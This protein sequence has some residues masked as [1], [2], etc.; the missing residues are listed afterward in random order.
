MATISNR[1]TGRDF[2]LKLFGIQDSTV[3]FTIDEVNGIRQR[4]QATDSLAGEPR[5]AKYDIFQ[6]QLI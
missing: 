6:S 4:F 2:S 1:R 3:R 5:K